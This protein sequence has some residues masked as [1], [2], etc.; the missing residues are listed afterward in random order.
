MPELK[1]GDYVRL[2]NAWAT[3]LEDGSV[4]HDFAPFIRSCFKIA[5]LNNYG[6]GCWIVP[7]HSSKRFNFSL[8]NIQP[9]VFLGSAM[10]AIR[11]AS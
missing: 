10:E 11:D 9:D 1:V 2:T 7:L 4:H 8:C 3:N 6:D 5:K